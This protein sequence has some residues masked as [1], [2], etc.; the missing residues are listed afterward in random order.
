MINN[1]KCSFFFIPTDHN[2]A[3]IAT[4]ISHPKESRQQLWWHGPSFKILEEL[5][6][7]LQNVSEPFEYADFIHR[8]QEERPEGKPEDTLETKTQ[9]YTARQGSP[10]GTPNTD[11]TQRSRRI[12]AI[13]EKPEDAPYKDN[14][15]LPELTEEM[16]NHLGK[17]CNFTTP[18][19]ALSHET[20]VTVFNMERHSHLRKLIRTRAWINRFLT[21]LKQTP[22]SSNRNS[23]VTKEPQPLTRTGERA[24]LFDIICQSQDTSHAEIKKR[25]H[26]GKKNQ[27]NKS[28]GFFS[29][30]MTSSDAEDVWENA[31]IYHLKKR[32]PYYLPRI[33]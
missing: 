12:R 28:L 9:P 27:L 30:N 18:K 32:S 14:L 26:L 5:K 3:D 7:T 23:V 24:A 29:I 20:T 31:T 15:D 8:T 33:I 25:L 19:F 22:H 16:R 11:H 6:T 2:P 1:Y 17:F 4:R 13:Q 10:E 21:N